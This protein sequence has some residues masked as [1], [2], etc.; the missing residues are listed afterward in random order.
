[1][2]TLRKRIRQ[3]IRAV[4]GDNTEE[5]LQVEIKRLKQ[6][7]R[8][9]KVM[10]EILRLPLELVRLDMGLPFEKSPKLP[11][12]KLIM[13]SSLGEFQAY[14]IPADGLVFYAPHLAGVPDNGE[15]MTDGFLH[16]L[17]E[18]RAWP[19]ETISS[20][21]ALTHGRTMLDIG[22]NIGLTSIPRAVLGLFD[23]IHA[24]EPE[25]RNLCCIRQ[26]IIENALTDR[27]T[28]WH[29]AVGQ[30]DGDIEFSVTDGMA[31]HHV[32]MAHT[33]PRSW[34]RFLSYR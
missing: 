19:V 10:Q 17:M 5:L 31:R 15:K 29:A 30:T 33:I 16:R 12:E 18:K 32:T 4:R 25:P 27:M 20:L 6:K 14:R 1:M 11:I 8:Q 28:A 2:S 26:A 3:I 13:G 23:H 7:I 22:A 34:L 21:L 24:F 9:T